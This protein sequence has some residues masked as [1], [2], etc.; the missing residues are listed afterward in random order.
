MVLS[1][2]R[3]RR[4]RRICAQPFPE[5]WQEVLDRDVEHYRRLGV[6]EQSKLRDDLRVLVAEKTWTGIDDLVVTDEMKVNVAA[7]ASLLLLGF[8]HDYFS[9]TSEIILHPRSY[10]AALRYR[11][12]A[13]IVES[14]PHHLGQA[15]YR[16]PV[17]LS[18][19]AAR[20]S[21]RDEDDG[22][23]VVLHEFAHKLDMAD[24]L[25]DGTPV[26][27]SRAAYRDW[28]KV[29]SLAF[30]ELRDRTDRGRATLLDKYGAS[31]E[32]EFF[33]CA[34]ECFFEKPRRLRERHPDL[35]DVLR[36]FYRQDPEVRMERRVEGA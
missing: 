22:R 16:G 20:A 5:P 28:V 31:N 19:T 18:W 7:Q 14:S 25:S 17:V 12:G 9:R 34:T 4:R 13:V 32:A 33:A 24:D 10:K 15:Y 30:N 3:N 1:W 23:N 21:G 35:Y 11:Q 2:F 8:E 26:L 29:M 36:Q 27:H 6:E